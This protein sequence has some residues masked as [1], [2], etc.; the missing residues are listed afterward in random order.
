MSMNPNLPNDPGTYPGQPA[1]QAY[2][3]NP[4]ADTGYV[5]GH[6]PSGPRQPARQFTPEEIRAL[7]R[8]KRL[9]VVNLLLFF[10]F[11]FFALWYTSLAAN[12]Q[13][14]NYW[15]YKILTS[16]VALL[17]VALVIR[18]EVVRHRLRRKYNLP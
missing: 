5:A 18:N 17:I 12:P 9:R 10:P 3:P 11:V 2:F 4:G 16:V 1:R 7:S 6:F 8:R 14:N 15:G 13:W